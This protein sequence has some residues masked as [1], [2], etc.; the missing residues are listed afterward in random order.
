MKLITCELKI[1]INIFVIN[2]DNW[3]VVLD[4]R[5]DFYACF[6]INGYES[7]PKHLSF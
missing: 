7:W 5:K 1:Y 2:V 3:Q 4:G 6:I